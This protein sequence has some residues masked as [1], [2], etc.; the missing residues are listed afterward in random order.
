MN[1]QIISNDDSWMSI[2]AMNS[3]ENEEAGQSWNNT[4]IIGFK[5]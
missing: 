2:V 3:P 1:E 4:K 5:D